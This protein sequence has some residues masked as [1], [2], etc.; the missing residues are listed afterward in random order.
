MSFTNDYQPYTSTG[1]MNPFPSLSPISSPM[2]SVT[3]ISQPT[4]IATNGISKPPTSTTTTRWRPR[5]VETP[6][7]AEFAFDSMEDALDSFAKGEFLVVMDDESR[8]NEG[9]L[10]IAGSM[11]TTEKMAWMIRY[12]RWV[13]FSY[14]AFYPRFSQWNS[15]Y[16]CIALPGRRLEELEIPMMYPQNQERH[17][18]AYTVTVDYKHGA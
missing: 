2:P 1:Y 15:G 16:I 4:A 5:I 13:G 10:I 6:A 17:R 3:S 7:R 14:F 12:T 11:C 8:E 18:T 9:D